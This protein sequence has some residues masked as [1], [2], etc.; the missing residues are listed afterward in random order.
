MCLRHGEN[1]EQETT[2]IHCALR[3]AIRNYNDSFNGSYYISKERERHDR[4]KENKN[5]IYCYYCHNAIRF[6]FNVHS[7]T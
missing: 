5:N 7:N 4:T 3:I 6:N 2:I 1:K